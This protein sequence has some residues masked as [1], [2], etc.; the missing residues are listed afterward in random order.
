M[1]SIRKHRNRWQ[2]QIRR[3]GVSPFSRSFIYKSD[4]TTWA[5]RIE[6]DIDKQKV[7]QENQADLKKPFSDLLV[8]YA[9]TISPTKKG[10]AIEQIR[11]RKIQASRLG[12]LKTGLITPLDIQHYIHTRLQTVSNDTVRRELGIIQ[13][14]F[15]TA[16]KV[17][18]IPLSQNPVANIR[19]PISGPSRTR[20]LAKS[21]EAIL[22]KAASAC[23]NPLI[24]P[25]I[26]FAIATAMRR[27]EILSAQWENFKIK[28]KTLSLPITK[29]G[30][31]REVPLSKEALKILERLKPQ[32]SGLIFPVS[33]NALQLTWNR[34][35][36]NNGIQDLRFHD[37]RH[38][39]ISRFFEMGLTIPE[40]ALI[41]GH[42]DIRMLFRY[43]HLKAS[44]V[45]D[46]LDQPSP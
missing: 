16:R 39:A 29:N 3:R 15:E 18:G 33:G 22:V 42:R 34:I 11:L 26:Q 40:V 24:L 27:G 20:R 9:K 36:S 35:V 25:V 13:H 7:G 2:V 43:T 17:W 19:K 12:C 14:V 6:A 46:K 1:A 41:S 45:A 23:Q 38:E 37:L 21:E 8:R 10:N 5:R 4:A 31:R 28:D 44:A 30:F 32:A